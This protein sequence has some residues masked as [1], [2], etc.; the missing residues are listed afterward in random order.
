MKKRLSGLFLFILS[1][2][3]TAQ[4]T[5][6]NTAQN[7]LSGVWEN[8]SRFV[9]FYSE[10]SSKQE[11][12][13]RTVLKPYY[14]FVYGT[15]IDKVYSIINIESSFDN[16]ENA[17]TAN[18]LIK[19]PNE[20]KK[21]LQPIF[22]TQKNLFTSFYKKT[23][24]Q[25]EKIDDGSTAVSSASEALE[26]NSLL[27]G[28]WIEQGYPNGI[29][30]HPAEQIKSFSAYFFYGGRYVKFRYWFDDLAYSDKK[31]F[32]DTEE[33]KFLFPKMIMHED[34]VYSCI[35]NI[36]SVLRNYETGTFKIEKKSEGEA[37]GIF[38]TL[39]KDG[40]GPGK[41]AISD[42]YTDYRLKFKESIEIHISQSGREFALGKPFL[43]R[44]AVTNLDKEIAEHNSKRRKP[45]EPD[46]I[47]DDFDYNWEEARKLQKLN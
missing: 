40:A 43:I 3:L 21:F 38:L 1:F 4:N 26:E 10:D 5:A 45:R 8:G 39:L 29:L 30:L 20:K 15:P 34:R 31:A 23:E 27:H 18:L 7:I 41:N 13:M 14:R 42:T 19:Y 16:T 12:N 35:T 37:Q 36:G 47:D 32:L 9:E 24:I 17:F 22:V 33:G 44:S 11:Q 6:E 2:T 28:F 25:K 46:I